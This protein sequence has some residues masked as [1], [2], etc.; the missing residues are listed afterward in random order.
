MGG[1]E[2]MTAKMKSS[3]EVLEGK[4]RYISQRVNKKD[5]YETQKK[6]S[7][8]LEGKKG[9]SNIYCI[10]I[11][12]TRKKE[13]EKHRRRQQNNQEKLPVFKGVNSRF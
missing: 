11:W 5:K 12:N 8:K 3:I 6:R 2:G 1:R 13:L 4:V 9:I 10:V 7:G